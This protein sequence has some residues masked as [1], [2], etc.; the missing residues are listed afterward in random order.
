MIEKKIAAYDGL[1]LSLREYSVSNPKGVFHLI[2]G[3]SEHKNRYDDFCEFLVEHGYSAVIADNRGHGESINN[4]YPIGHMDSLDQV[5]K[6]VQT[7]RS[8]IEEEYPGIPVILFGHSFGTMIARKFIQEHDE[9]Y[10]HLILSGAPN[11]VNI[12]KIGVGIAKMVVSSSG[13][14]GF[15][16]VLTSL[17]KVGHDDDWLC[18][19]EET[20][21]DYRNDPLCGFKYTNGGNYT[22]F[23]S[24]EELHNYDG[25]KVKNPELKILFVSGID[26]PIIGGTKGLQDSID[27]LKKVGYRNIDSILYQNMKHEIL[28][29]KEKQQVYDD[30]LSFVEK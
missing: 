2:H 6:D 11:Y 9:Q 16:R 24:V 1:M 4:S 20:L 28:K 12:I 7:I 21:M 8:Y 15:S 10:T 22:M 23:K 17:N 19:D 5:V 26:D 3:A 30:I 14:L 27:S 25:Y 29:E 13:G 18:Y